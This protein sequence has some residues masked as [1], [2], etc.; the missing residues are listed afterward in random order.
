MVRCHA[1]LV[2]ENEASFASRIYLHSDA[3]FVID[4]RKSERIVAKINVTVYCAFV[5]GYDSAWGN[6]CSFLGL[7]CMQSA[8][9]SHGRRRETRD[10]KRK[11]TSGECVCVC[12]E[13]RGR[14][15]KRE[16]NC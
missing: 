5:C 9:N 1:V 6:A 16:R 14:E 15:R 13:E 4:Q 2:R 12:V 3:L 10:T 8:K 7:A 11:D